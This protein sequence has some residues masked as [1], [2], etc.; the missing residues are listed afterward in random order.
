MFAGYVGH[1][2][3]AGAVYLTR[4][5]LQTQFPYVNP[6]SFVGHTHTSHFSNSFSRTLAASG[7]AH[8][9]PIVGSSAKQEQDAKSQIQAVYDGLTAA[10]DL[11]EVEPRKLLAVFSFHI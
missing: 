3:L 2:F 6:Q 11:E 1:H 7:T 9:G 5:R 8:G 4:P 10:E